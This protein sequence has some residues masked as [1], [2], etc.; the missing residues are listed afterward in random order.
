MVPFDLGMH[1]RER[2]AKAAI[3][4][5]LRALE[6]AGVTWSSVSLPCQDRKEYLDNVRWFAAEVMPSL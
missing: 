6:A 3:L 1:S 4:D 5:Q 2:P